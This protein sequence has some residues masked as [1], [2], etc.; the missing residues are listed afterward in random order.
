[1]LIVVVATRENVGGHINWLGP[2]KPELGQTGFQEK[3]RSHSRIC[4][5]R[6]KFFSDQTDSQSPPGKENVS[7]ID[8]R[9]FVLT[10]RVEPA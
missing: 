5:E 10:T 3:A 4:I 8:K 9:M 2:C 6:F 1:M 7:V